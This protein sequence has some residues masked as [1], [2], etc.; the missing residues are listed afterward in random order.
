MAD[1]NLHLGSR[2]TTTPSLPFSPAPSG[3]Q[4]PLPKSRSYGQQPVAEARLVPGGSRD[5]LP[6]RQGLQ[7]CSWFQL[8]VRHTWEAADA[9]PR[10]QVPPPRGETERSSGLL[11]SA[12][13][14][15]SCCE[16]ERMNSTLPPDRCQS[17]SMPRHG[18]CGASSTHAAHTQ[19]T[20]GGRP[21][22]AS[23]GSPGTPRRS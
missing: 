19:P 12:C 6:R 10:T 20:T 15:S 14:R 18:V 8:P 2:W 7:S 16:R 1:S 22:Q 23:G 3:P 13:P 11:A 9:G 5:V 21:R 4:L 17:F